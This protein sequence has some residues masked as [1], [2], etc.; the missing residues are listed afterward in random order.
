MSAAPIQEL[1]AQE[2][3]VLKL[4]VQ[5]LTSREAGVL[6]GISP[7]T[8]EFHRGHIMEKYAARNMA[9]LMRLVYSH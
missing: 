3:V 6:L 2:A 7:R 5:G 8:V 1:T 9:D 4:I